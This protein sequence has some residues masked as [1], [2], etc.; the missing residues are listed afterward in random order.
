MTEFQGELLSTTDPLTGDA[1]DKVNAGAALAYAI[2]HCPK[3]DAAGFFVS[4]P[5]GVVKA[6]MKACEA[7]GIGYRSTHAVHVAE[8]ADPVMRSE[9][10]A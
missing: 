3:D 4:M 1:I 2:Y 10:P 9:E 8:Q 5:N 7:Y 6:Y